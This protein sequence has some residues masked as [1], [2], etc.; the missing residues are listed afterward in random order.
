ME[1]KEKPNSSSGPPASPRV[2]AVIP[3][4][5]GSKR[6]PRKNIMNLCGHP[7]I[8]YTIRAAQ[9]CRQISDLLVSSEDKEIRAAARAYGAPVPFAR[10]AELSGDRI[11][12]IDVVGHAMAFMEEKTGRPYDILVLLQPTCPIRDP[13]HIDDAILKLWSSELET[14]VS[15]KGPF[16]KRDPILKRIE[17]GVLEPFCR[18]DG[19]EKNEPFYL[20]NASIYAVKRSYF[21]RSKRLISPKQIP[22]VM[23]AYH[24][25]DID[26]EADFRV[27]ETYLNYLTEAGFRREIL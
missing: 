7:L 23:D 6:L 1:N 17:D 15:V 10:P 19:A 12:N 24:S 27:A 2:L 3:A 18:G 4:R 13:S 25:V 16:Q 26:T 20:Y 5:G 9:R 8:A 22:I 14:S 11:R 21:I